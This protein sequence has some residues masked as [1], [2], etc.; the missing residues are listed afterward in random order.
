MD[1]MQKWQVLYGRA[2][3]P[4]HASGITQWLDEQFNSRWTPDELT[5]ALDAIAEE[6]RAKGVKAYAPDSPR[7]KSAMIKARYLARQGQGGGAAGDEFMD[8]VRRAMVRSDDHMRRWEILCEPQKNGLER[9]TTIEECQR[10]DRWAERRWADWRTTIDDMKTR[11]A[12][13]LHAAI[14]AIFARKGDADKCG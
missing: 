13:E 4:N 11:L 3:A 8:S 5:A 12:H 7:I 6:D 10:L 9:E 1:W 14:G 2:I